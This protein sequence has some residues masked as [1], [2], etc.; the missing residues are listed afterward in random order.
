MIF[1]TPRLLVRRWTPDNLD[2]FFAIFGEPEVWRYLPGDPPAN[3]AEAG[4]FMERMLARMRQ[5]DGMGSFAVIERAN[6]A[7]IGNVML[8][9]LENGPEI[10][11]GYHIAMPTWGRG[12]ATEAARGAVRYGFESLGLEEIHGVVVPDNIA[13]RR[14][15]EKA[16]FTWLRRDRFYGLDCDVLRLT[17]AAWNGPPERR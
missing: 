5:W 12:F 9:P 16:G 10:E 17:R 13:S 3:I 2:A 8:R 6:D 11:V 7:I 4:G 14:V 15:L 1:E